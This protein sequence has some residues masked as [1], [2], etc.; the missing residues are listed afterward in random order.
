[1]FLGSKLLHGLRKSATVVFCFTEPLA[2]M[3]ACELLP[4]TTVSRSKPSLLLA[5]AGHEKLCRSQVRPTTSYCERGSRGTRRLLRPTPWWSSNEEVQLFVLE[6][7]RLT[8]REDL[9]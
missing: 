3:W 2:S 5:M 6:A 7:S 1:M 4:E 8:T 9:G